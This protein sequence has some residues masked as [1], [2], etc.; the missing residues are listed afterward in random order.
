MTT[1]LSEGS[2]LARS[3]KSCGAEC[4][5]DADS[6]TLTPA[7][8]L[9]KLLGVRRDVSRGAHRPSGVPPPSWTPERLVGSIRPGGKDVRPCH[10]DRT[11]R[12][13]TRRSSD[14]KP[15]SCTGKRPLAE[16]DRERPR[17]LLGV[18]PP[19]GEAGRASISSLRASATTN[20]TLIGALSP[21]SSRC[22]SPAP[23]AQRE[24]LHQESRP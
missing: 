20:S 2:S 12:S 9:V 11:T 5:Q 24:P 18:A 17:R 10:G 15:S 21:T 22:E 4:L 13:R 1:S 14:G 3:A 7:A 16:G 19:L 23:S 8:P 6:A